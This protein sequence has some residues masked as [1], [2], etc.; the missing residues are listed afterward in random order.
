MKFMHNYN[1][2]G[3]AIA[4]GL[5]PISVVDKALMDVLNV[6]NNQTDSGLQELLA[7]DLGLYLSTLR[8]CSQL[9]SVQRLLMHTSIKSSVDRLGVKLPA[10][11]TSPVLHVLS[12]KL[13]VPGGYFGIGAHQDYTSTQASKNAIVAWV[14]LCDIDK[15]FYPLEVIPSSHKKGVL[16]GVQKENYF[17]VSGVKDKDFV[18][19]SVEKGDVIFMSVLTV[20][21]SCL[22]GRKGVRMSASIRYED[23]AEPSFIERGYPCKYKREYQQ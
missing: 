22:K 2:H 1:K 5:L 8:L 7:R 3:Y 15:D 21:R 13:K 19:L 12:E 14:P 9:V 18:K 10:F 16:P 6:I 23:A 20:H 11:Q 17:E 4:K